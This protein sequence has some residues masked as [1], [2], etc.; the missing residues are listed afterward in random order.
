[1]NNV[2]QLQLCVAMYVGEYSD[3]FPINDVVGTS[4]ATNAWI[5]GNVQLYTANYTNDVT[6]ASLFPYNT[7]PK[8]YRC[9]SDRAYLTGLRGAQVPHNRSYAISVGISCNQ[10][11]TTLRK[12]G[13]AT[14]TGLTSVFLEENSASIDN[15]AIGINGTNLMTQVWNMP[16]ARHA[17][18]CNASFLDGHVEKWRWL[19]PSMPSLNND[20]SL[21]YPPS[22]SRPDPTTN[23]FQGQ[24][25]DGGSD[26]L[27]LALSLPQ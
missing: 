23:P 5:K 21:N 19:G 25:T 3:A 6:Q 10:L 2:K 24:G 26:W 18:T 14:R 17:L 22:F 11:G 4:A 7:H 8:I 13:Q 16:A 20:P 12:Q 9:P 1:L 15:G 27:R